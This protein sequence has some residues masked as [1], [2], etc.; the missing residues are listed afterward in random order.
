V[1]VNIIVPH[2]TLCAAEDDIL[3]L[4]TGGAGFLGGTVLQALLSRGERVRVLVL[5]DD[6]LV[7]QLPECAQICMGDLLNEEDLDRFF[8][9]EEGET[10]TVIHCASLI[11]MS[12]GPVDKVYDVNVNGAA[13]IIAHCLA[14]NIKSLIYV[15]S[16]HA[17]EELP[18]GQAMTEPLLTNPDK[19]IG[20]YAKTKAQ[21]ADLVMRARKEKGLR[22]S[23]VYPSGLCGPGDNAAGNLTQLFLDYFAGRI[24][25]GVRGGYNFVD[26]RDVAEAI[27]NLAQQAQN[28][29]DYI[30]AGEYIEVMDIL[31]AFHRLF[32]GKKIR[33]VCP[34]WLA[35]MALPVLSLSYKIRKIKA[36][37]SRYALKT[38]TFNSLFNS[39][40][41]K[42]DLSFR[43]R[44]MEETL[45]DTG[46]WLKA[47]G[48]IQLKS[49]TAF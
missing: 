16:V 4:L 39:D 38:I 36:I 24:P 31:D 45:K 23:I 34:I 46:Q 11:S 9:L 2:K 10:A 13:H 35:K 44:P 8:H 48:R 18:R 29:G 15:S 12:L 47:R 33:F 22:A 40:K 14:N 49:G 20:C 21:A 7:N 3:Y 1:I 32:G 30:L 28:G 6:P 42:R 43:P 37:F 27:V 5:P 41:A 17:I 19:V 26:V 25:V